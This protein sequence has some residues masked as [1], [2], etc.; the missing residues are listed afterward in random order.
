ML[1][2][3]G[4][5]RPRDL[6]IQDHARDGD[7]DGAPYRNQERP[8]NHNPGVNSKLP[9]PGPQSSS[10]RAANTTC[11]IGRFR[12]RGLSCRVRDD[13]TR[14]AATG[15]RDACAGSSP[16]G[17]NS[18]DAAENGLK[19][20]TICWPG[21]RSRASYIRLAGHCSRS[22]QHAASDASP[23]V[24]RTD[25][26]DADVA[27]ALGFCRMR[28]I[29]HLNQLSALSGLRLP[30]G[31]ALPGQ[32]QHRDRRVAPPRLEARVFGPSSTRH[33]L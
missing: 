14:R 31:S 19:H 2:E 17:S 5:P 33:G 11:A 7:H 18:V 25:K 16:T 10:F 28:L 26:I 4:H 20:S 30:E 8:R 32:P 3:K 6:L 27:L 24:P 9:L 22:G 29:C 15:C 23:D 21:S 12:N 13:L 1:E